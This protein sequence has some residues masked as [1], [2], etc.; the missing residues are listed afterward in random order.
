L[1]KLAKIDSSLKVWVGGLGKDFPWKKLEKHF[2][3]LTGAK[4]TLT[5]VYP[6]AGFLVNPGSSKF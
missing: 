2:V 3:E 4:P 1:D 5:H 6:K